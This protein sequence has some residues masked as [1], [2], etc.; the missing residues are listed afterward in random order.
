[1][2]F[3][4]LLSGCKGKGNESASPNKVTAKVDISFDIISSLFSVFNVK[5]PV[6]NFFIILIKLLSTTIFPSSIIVI[7]VS[8]DTE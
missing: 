5:R 2:T 7:S 3:V 6:E 8:S 1:M 4:L